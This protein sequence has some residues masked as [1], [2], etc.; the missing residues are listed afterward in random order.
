[1]K[2]RVLSLAMA[3]ALCLGLMAVPAAAADA[4]EKE[5]PEPS[6]T[7]NFDTDTLESIGGRTFQFRH[8]YE[9]DDYYA[10]WSEVKSFTPTSQMG[11]V[12]PLG[13]TL[14]LQT[15]GN[16]L[17]SDFYW[18]LE[19]WSDPEGDGIYE[20]RAGSWNLKTDT[21]DIL[22]LGTELPKEPIEDDFDTYFRL[23]GTN[24]LIPRVFFYDKLND[25]VCLT[26]DFLNECFGPNTFIQLT[27]GTLEGKE[28]YCHYLLTGEEYAPAPSDPNTTNG[29]SH[30]SS[31]AV[32]NINNA[33]AAEL[34]PDWLMGTDLTQN[35]TRADFAASAL[36]LYRAMG[37]S[38]EGVT[39]ENPF[40]D[41]TS[42]LQ[43]YEDILLVKALGI[44]SGKGS[45]LFD[46]DGTLTR[47]EA[48]VMLCNVYKALGK[49]VPESAA[50]AFADND[51]IAGWA[52]SAVA[53]MNGNKV[54]NGKGENKFDPQAFN[55]REE[56]LTMALNMLN[57]LK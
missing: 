35:I 8:I 48:A 18:F 11:K 40:S 3:L 57:K 41:V 36:R 7:A 14:N 24:L 42:D 1:M 38:T 9:D 19:A 21:D 33:E 44:A 12:L 10:Y 23:D 5:P 15:G 50:T 39:T 20:Q 16:E 54:V 22:P 25:P 31:W 55:T 13:V 56:A 27:V 4:E 2:K 43:A 47:E 26:T 34:V 46:P 29:G 30:V 45:G 52:V 28:W 37:G 6:L 51:S 49:S 32:G 17:Q 53:F